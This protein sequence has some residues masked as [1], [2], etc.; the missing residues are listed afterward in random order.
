MTAVSRTSRLTPGSA[1]MPVEVL[2]T[3]IP[4]PASGCVF[5]VDKI[6]YSLSGW[7]VLLKET[8]DKEWHEYAFEVIYAA[9]LPDVPEIPGLI[10]AWA[11][12]NVASLPTR[13]GNT[14]P[15]GKQLPVD[16]GGR[17]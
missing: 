1:V 11:A 10:E 13:R 8:G 15:A 4:L 2:R 7:S 6:V 5:T 9:P 16:D 12:H 14:P 3:F 17:W